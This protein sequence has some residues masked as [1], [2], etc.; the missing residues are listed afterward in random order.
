M[1]TSGK[2]SDVLGSD[3][4]QVTFQDQPINQYLF[5]YFDKTWRDRLAVLR[6]GQSIHVIGQIERVDTVG[7]TLTKCEL[8]DVQRS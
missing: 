1:S 7:V 3:N 5:M 8:I 4:L 6:P 2:L